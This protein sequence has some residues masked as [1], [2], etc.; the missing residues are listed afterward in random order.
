VVQSALR[1]AFARW[2]MPGQIRVGNGYPWGSAG[3]LPTDLALWWIGL[4]IDAH[5][6]RPRQPRENGVVERGQGVGKGWSE[7]QTCD[8]AAELQRR[9]NRLDRL[10]REEYPVGGGLSR[11][12]LYPGLKHSGRRY[13]HGSE[14]RLWRLERV[15]E[16]LTG[17]AV[18]RRI[19]PKGMVSIYDTS[20]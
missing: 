11:M 16:H 14:A 19:N 2:G 20:Y 12:E 6:N 13:R 8:S 4:G 3:E 18:S 1:R 17:Y 15:L 10:Q 5:W 7:P 9:F